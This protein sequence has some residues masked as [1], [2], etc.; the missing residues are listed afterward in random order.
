MS[1]R[2]FPAAPDAAPAA[3]G[4]AH[5]WRVLSVGVLANVAFSAA[6]T[7]IPT[8]AIW[9]RGAYRLDNGALGLVLGALGLGAALFELP[10]GI[11]ADRW[12]DRR[13]LLTGLAAMTAL[14]VA[15]ALLVVPRG[16]SIPPLAPLA[17]AMAL[18]GLTGGSVNGASGRA[19]MRWFGDHERG[20]AMSIRQTAVPLGGGL[21][22]AL[23]PPLASTA[24]FAAVYGALAAAGAV[25]AA[26]TWRWLHEPGDDAVATT[27]SA[28]AG[29]T[30]GTAGAGGPLRDPVIGR[31]V[32]G[33]GLLCVP[34]SAILAFA[35]VFLHD[36]AGFGAV[37]IGVVMV[38]IQLG[39]MIL[40]VWSGRATDRLGN[41]RAYVRG[42]TRLAAGLF[43]LLALATLAAAS[44]PS[45][46]SFAVVAVLLV[47]AG[48]GVSAW[49]GVGYTELATLAGAARAGTALGMANTM[50]YTGFFVTPLAIPALLA[51]GSWG[52]VWFIAAAVALLAYP[53]FP[54]PPRELAAP[55]RQRAGRGA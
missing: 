38:T 17:A 10:W 5:R 13:V 35:T 4:A 53:C 20:L 40:R 47:A 18:V 37:P 26:L 55:L 43:V 8:T 34:Q 49:H 23:L 11:A 1:P 54:R 6:A 15:M 30:V 29:G 3:R 44:R 52:L 27:G 22:A 45:G 19:V 2:P 32:L 28:G 39:A 46:T 21:G 42:V 48:I 36:F 25:A 41:R 50:V 31:F 12:G 9:L 16:A 24:G 51:R 7:G 14:L 33:I